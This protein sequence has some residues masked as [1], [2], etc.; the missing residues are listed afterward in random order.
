MS[1]TPSNFQPN[2]FS[3]GS[4]RLYAVHPVSLWNGI[5]SSPSSN[6]SLGNEFLSEAH[7]QT[8]PSETPASDR[9]EGQI[10]ESPVIS[11]CQ[12]AEIGTTVF[13]SKTFDSFC[14]KSDV[15]TQ[16]V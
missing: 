13:P 16:H 11:A 15:R 3:M 7:G 12:R 2:I 9:R 4:S 10:A 5:K 6:V 14:K 8:S 1:S